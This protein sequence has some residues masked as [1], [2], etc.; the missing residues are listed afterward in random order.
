MMEFFCIPNF[1]KGS[2]NFLYPQF[3][4]RLYIHLITI[5]SGIEGHP[6]EDNLVLSSKNSYSTNDLSHVSPSQLDVKFELSLDG[7]T[8]TSTNTTT[9]TNTNNAS[10]PNGEHNKT[11]KFEPNTTTT[12][13]T[14]NVSSQDVLPNRTD[15]VQVEGASNENEKDNTQLNSFVNNSVHNSGVG[16]GSPRRDL[17]DEK[18]VR[19]NRKEEDEEEEEELMVTFNGP[20]RGIDVPGMLLVYCWSVRHPTSVIQSWLRKPIWSS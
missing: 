6:S 8:F 19:T 7:P 4:K 18:G 1:L 11:E 15:G 20:E 14:G 16:R 13:T 3:L 9:T 2:W 17:Q 10:I 12:T 5:F